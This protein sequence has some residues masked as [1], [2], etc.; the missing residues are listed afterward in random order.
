MKTSQ[1]L[2]AII[3]WFVSACTDDTAIQ[4][5]ESIQGRKYMIFTDPW[6]TITDNAGYTQETIFNNDFT[7]WNEVNG[8][9]IEMSSITTTDIYNGELKQRT[10][11][12]LWIDDLQIMFIQDYYS[13]Q[14]QYWEIKTLGPSKMVVDLVICTDT[15]DD[16]CMVYSNIEF[17]R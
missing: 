15:S 13:L 9:K 11:F 1:Y 3:L 8:E 16:D 12:I 4:P 2:F 14:K 5:V 17:G 10:E 7:T 6:Y